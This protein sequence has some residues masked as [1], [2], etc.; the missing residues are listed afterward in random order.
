MAKRTVYGNSPWGAWF[1]QALER[2]NDVGRLKRG[3]TY[4]NTGRVSSFKVA[5]PEVSAR[6]A[7][8]YQPWY[9]VRIAF[10]P[11][12]PKEQKKLEALIAGNGAL[13]ADIRTGLLPETLIEALAEAGIDLMPRNWRSIKKSCDCP[14]DGNPCK[15]MAAVY[16]LLVRHIDQHPRTLFLLRGFDLDAAFPQ[17]E[18]AP[19][20]PAF[21]LAARKKE[22]H[23]DGDAGA[24]GGAS[25]SG[26]PAEAGV[27]LS[28]GGPGPLAAAS[29]PGTP[30]PLGADGETP[31][32]ALPLLRALLRP[33]PAFYE[34][35]DFHAI[36]CAAYERSRA[37]LSRLLSAGPA[38][39][40][41]ASSAPSSRHE[42][43]LWLAESRY[44]LVKADPADPRELRIRIEH[45]LGGAV[46]LAG[47][48]LATAFLALEEDRGSDSFRYF[49]HLYRF[50]Y[51]MIGSAAFRP[52]VDLVP[53]ARAKA[54]G[55]RIIWQPLAGFGSG[56]ASLEALAALAPPLLPLGEKDTAD[57][58]GTTLWLLSALLGDY[59]RATVGGKPAASRAKDPLR[60]AFFAGAVL[61]VRSG[62]YEQTPKAVHAWLSILDLASVKSAGSVRASDSTRAAAGGPGARYR[63]ILDGDF[64][65]RA[66]LLWQGAA[67]TG[68]ASRA[69]LGADVG[70]WLDLCAAAQLP[71]SGAA[72][73][74]A[75]LLADYLPELSALRQT[76]RV[77]LDQQRLLSFLEE[78]AGILRHLGVEVQTPRALSKALKPRLTVEASSK[79][80]EKADT[81]AAK[82]LVAQLSL[83]DVMTYHWVV[84]L[85]DETYSFEEFSALM[86]NAQKLVMLKDGYTLLDP[87]V[88]RDLLEQASRPVQGRDLLAAWLDGA[89]GLKAPE[90]RQLEKLFTVRDVAVPKG[91][92]ATLREYQ[93]HGYRWIWNN[94]QNGFGCLLADDMGLGKTLQAIAVMLKAKE[95]G[96]LKE[97]ALVVVPASLLV[98]W[99]RELARFAPKLAVS[100]YY[101]PKRRVDPAADV[102]IGSYETVAR[103]APKLSK[104][105]FALLVLDEAHGLK[106]AATKR[107]RAINALSIP[108]R[109]ALSGTPV[110]NRLEDLR[111]LFDLILPGY[112]GTASEF[113]KAWRVPIELERDADRAELL[114]RRTAPF[115]LRRL[116][117]DPGIAP[118]LPPKTVLDHYAPLCP[119]QAAL[120]EAVLNT[121]AGKLALADPSLGSK[122]SRSGS[123]DEDE[124][125]F[126]RKKNA[127]LL[128]LLT[129]LKQVCNHPRAY[130][131]ES[132]ATAEISGKTLLLLDL[133]RAILDA[134][135]K[136]LVFS[137]YVGTL[138]ILK[139]IIG[140]ELGEDCLVLDGSMSQKQRNA[141]VDAFQNDSSRRIFLISLKAGG[142]GLNLT[143]ASRVIHYDLWYNPAVEDQASDRAFRIGQTRQVF[144]HRLIAANTFEE[145]IDHMLKAK[146]ELAALGVSTGESWIAD[147]DPA[148][149]REL[150]A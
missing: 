116:K 44:A 47:L 25:R 122:K 69:G 102:I 127:A 136:V 21:V 86:G 82:N 15:H 77:L 145:R 100:L 1:M 84:A 78:A 40:F 10:P 117:T 53:R 27:S 41:A 121:V 144:V 115:L 87:A 55:M 61:D 124:A 94:L 12:T 96:R 54:G 134:R 17:L 33:K 107:A 95:S 42:A 31:E 105:A 34:H 141:A 80:G 13:Q 139:E 119:E 68:K 26:A 106:N 140:D 19:I 60:E 16:Y 32:S 7:G 58:A 29:T 38:D 97:P 43:A 22:I 71:G 135:E 93:L 148:E 3:R 108:A 76:D 89:P 99:Q 75:A 103:D 112:L 88:L 50:F 118:E 125:A 14:D 35:G 64:G 56:A 45:P 62:R 24:P 132:P 63:F 126:R 73:S 36:L 18:E 137:Q 52:V 109:L 6:V 130:D 113:R 66:Q 37:K 74:L 101:G 72:L 142:V 114:R 133:L 57:G 9:H 46:E 129:A 8:N 39:P 70:E 92:A 49:Y 28:P 2:G 67:S 4:A 83:E 5:G 123:T 150:F 59:M 79:P 85:G 111:A 128:K 149:L 91:L 11:F 65:L 120:Y 131:G 51:R 30:S 104:Q 138:A 146:Q 20:P 98:N 23:T 90:R 110:E 147:L 143:A 48:E 81:K